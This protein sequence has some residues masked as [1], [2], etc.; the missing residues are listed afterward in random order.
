VEG[1]KYASFGRSNEAYFRLRKVQKVP[2]QFG[3]IETLSLSTGILIQVYGLAP[4]D[5]IVI[6]AVS[7]ACLLESPCNEYLVKTGRKQS[8][9]WILKI[10]GKF[11][12]QISCIY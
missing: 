5:A 10:S 4:K 1:K 2:D 6:A 9:K 12:I 8:Q 3:L 7:D 11:K